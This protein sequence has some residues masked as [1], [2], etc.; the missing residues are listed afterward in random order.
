MI[1]CIPCGYIYE[2]K[3]KFKIL[4]ESW[5]CPECGASIQSFSEI[6]VSS[7]EKTISNRSIPLLGT[8][9]IN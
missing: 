7:P 2:N 4:P 3:E 8:G 6:D 5:H 1:I 9:G